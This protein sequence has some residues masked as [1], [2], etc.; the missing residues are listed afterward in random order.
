MAQQA[1]DSA[2]VAA[3]VRVRSLAQGHPPA[4]GMTKDTG[5]LREVENSEKVGEL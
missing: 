5:W 2:W 4:R 3:V 1:H